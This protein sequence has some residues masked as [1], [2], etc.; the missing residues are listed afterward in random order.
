MNTDTNKTKDISYKIVIPEDSSTVGD[1]VLDD[2]QIKTRE[3]GFCGEAL[4][5][6]L[7]AV[8]GEETSYLGK[9]DWSSNIFTCE[10]TEVQ[11]DNQPNHI[12][13]S[14][15]SV[16]KY[17]HKSIV[18]DFCAAVPLVVNLLQ[19]PA[20]NSKLT[21][22]KD[23]FSTIVTS[24]SIS[25]TLPIAFMTSFKAETDHLSISIDFSGSAIEVDNFEL[26]FAPMISNTL[27]EYEQAFALRKVPNN[28]SYI[29]SMAS[30]ESIRLLGNLQLALSVNW[31]RFS[32]IS[33]FLIASPLP[34]SQVGLVWIVP[35][36]EK[37]KQA[38]LAVEI[39]NISQSELDLSIELT[40][41]PL[42][43]LLK[44]ISVEKLQPNERRIID[45]PCV[46]CVT[47]L[48]ELGYS[49]KI[50]NHVYRPLFKTLIN[51]K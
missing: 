9:V 17:E 11:S 14:E 5:I 43:P 40:D 2:N 36:L 18:R 6:W 38:P 27:S 7:V 22:W 16:K 34:P 42:I 30:S 15:V 41:R 48:H 51:I 46:P 20:K 23:D 32:M 37:L 28:S 8:W 45:V 50:A 49:I 44:T 10:L 47:G 4:I 26:H 31:N 24:K 33:H 3:G 35:N 13:T 19:H 39:T 1:L 25:I 29:L 21:V 12:S